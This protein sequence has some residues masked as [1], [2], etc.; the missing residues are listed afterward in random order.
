[1]KWESSNNEVATV[2][3][4]GTIKAISKGKA[5]ITVAATDGSD[6]F[7]ECSAVISSEETIETYVINY[8]ETKISINL[9]RTEMPGNFPILY[10]YFD[11][12]NN[13]DEKVYL[14]EARC[15]FYQND[16]YYD[17]GAY[18]EPGETLNI[19]ITNKNKLN[20]FFELHGVEHKRPNW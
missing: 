11:I 3:E 1:M 18:I 7:A 9:T 10:C 12:T 16:V 19:K 2:D 13:G 8:I 6:C 15:T 17:E 14:R 20:W 4:N 5:T